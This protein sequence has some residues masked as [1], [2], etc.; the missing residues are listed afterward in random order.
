M[1]GIAVVIFVVADAAL[2]INVVRMLG[3]HLADIVVIFVTACICRNTEIAVA[4]GALSDS[5]HASVPGAVGVGVALDGVGI[6]TFH[7]PNN[8][9]V[10]EIAV[11]EKVTGFGSVFCAVIVGNT[12]IAGV[13]HTVLF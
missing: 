13:S 11:K 7:I 1:I 5:D 3:L 6:F 9:H 10:A 12:E 4:D 2:V 8:A